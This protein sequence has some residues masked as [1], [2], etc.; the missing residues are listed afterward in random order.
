MAAALTVADVLIGGGGTDT[1]TITDDTTTTDLDN[2]SG[3]EII[4]VTGTS[5]NV[6]TL[7]TTNSSFIAAGDNLTFTNN[8]AQALTLTIT[9]NTTT[10]T[11][12]YTG[13]TGI[14]SI[15]GG[16]GADTIDGAA[17]RDLLF[18]GI[19]ADQLSGGAAADSLTGGAGAD[20]F[21]WTSTS[22]AT[23]ATESEVT[24]GTDND[25]AAGTVGDKVADFVTGTDKL[26]FAAAAVTNA[27]GTEI[28][29]MGSIVAGGIVTNVMRF[30]Y[31][32]T[33]AAQYT[34]TG[35]YG[36]ALGLINALDTSAVAI[37]DSFIIAMDNDTN[38]DLYY[39]KQISAANT[40]AAQDL[41]LI[42]QLTGVTGLAT[43]DFVSF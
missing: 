16:T 7:A 17:G 22:A 40:I 39:V 24:A 15:T 10:G 28:D 12:T 32:N 18:G 23:F 27:T 33:T 13:N 2:V 43:G 38:T 26:Y 14:D 25:F 8:A 36:V 21:K 20:I 37:G 1:L 34:A 6:Y 42:G 19:G 30:V 41:T 35:D 29:T 31:L 9:N 11:L 5:I 3:I 4:T